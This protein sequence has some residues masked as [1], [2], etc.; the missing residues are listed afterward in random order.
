M[1]KLIIFIFLASILNAQ[2]ENPGTHFA[3]WKTESLNR[4]G[5]TLN[6]I[7]HYPALS[8]GSQAPIDPSGG[9]YPVIAFGH[10]FLMQNSNY[11]SLFRHL[12]THGYIVIAPQFPDTQH[13]QLADDLIFCVN[14]I[15]I[16]GSDPASIFYELVDVEKTGLSGHS[17]GGGASLLAASRD[18]TI[19][20]VAPLA[21]AETN[22]SAI[23]I[24]NQ[25]N[26][27]VYLISAQNDGITPPASHQ[28]LMYNNANP[29]KSL[30]L[31]KGGNHTRFMD[32]A[33][34]DWTDPRGYRTRTEQL[35]LTRRYLTAVY[36]LFLKEDITM[37]DYA[38]GSFAESDTMMI[39]TKELKPLIPLKFDL[40]Y[41]DGQLLSPPVDFAWRKTFSLNGN[42]QVIYNVEIAEDSL[43]SNHFFVS[44]DLIDT[45]FSLIDI[46]EGNYFWRV[47][48]RTSD[49]TVTYS[50][51][52]F[53][54]TV[55]GLASTDEEN[56]Y[57]F[58]LFQNYPN[59]F[60]PVTIIKW[61]TEAGAYQ[62]LKVFD[63]LGNEVAVLVNEFREAGSYQTQFDAAGL[64]SGVYFYRLTINDRVFVKKMTFL[65]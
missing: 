2:P 25:V 52:Y 1:N 58:V 36:N 56:D 15:R 48:S 39:F 51:G 46:P 65:R 10:G 37:W 22:P 23:N 41:P 19:N 9:P 59:P 50:S 44:I 62:T 30:P 61:S 14:F 18:S 35:M 57:S 38:F 28:Q 33:T 26:A 60:N 34:W 20:V 29:V 17:M 11:T 54:F 53:T 64:T 27:V 55:S 6:C 4:N 42:D 21:A 16:S 32:I 3:G 47:K 43:F 12:A 45:V 24:M 13:G 8:E 63:T 31:I 49:S 5:R 40:L 7:I